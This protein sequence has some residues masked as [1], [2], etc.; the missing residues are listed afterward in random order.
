MN[1]KQV[2]FSV[3]S[4]IF[5]IFLFSCRQNRFDSIVTNSNQ[6]PLKIVRF[7]Q[8]LF[9]LPIDSLE[10]SYPL[11]V[12]KHRQFADM[13][14]QGIIRIGKPDSP[15]YY[16]YLKHFLTDTMVQNSYK[17]ATQRFP[18]G[19]S[20]FERELQTAFARFNHFFPKYTLPVIYTYVSGYNL[21]LAIDD[22]LLAI[23]LDRYLGR[24]TIQYALLGIPVYQ[25]RKMHPAKVASDAVRAWLYGTFPFN[26]SINNLLSNMIYEG[27]V[28]YLTKRML[29]HQPDSLIFGFT[30]DQYKW[31]LSN[32]EA[33]WT[34]L[35]ENKLLFTTNT[36]EINKMINDAPFTSGFPRESPGRAVVWLGYRI[37]ERFMERNTEIDLSNLVNIT[38]YQSILTRAKYKP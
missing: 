29:T 4:L 8:A 32:E 28:M 31:C 23:G 19:Q 27:E 12:S 1:L 18:V 9:S 13:F 20:D 22:S 34:Y 7:E 38:D 6:N 16:A 35:I 17:M 36:V 33:M 21:S 26:D 37:V 3:V 14:T 5:V 11:L 25:Q 10:T 15:S 30:P 24:G 2:A